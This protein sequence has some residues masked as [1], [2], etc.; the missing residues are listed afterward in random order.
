MLL[1][2]TVTEPETVHELLERCLQYSINYVK[3]EKRLIEAIHRNGVRAITH[4]CGDIHR[5]I[6]KI[7]TNGTD[8]IDVD[9][10]NDMPT[11]REHTFV[12]AGRDF[13]KLA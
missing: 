11:L 12:R 4:I 5:T 1:V 13:G 7:S 10:A 9:T 3:Y 6:E 8:I 2:G